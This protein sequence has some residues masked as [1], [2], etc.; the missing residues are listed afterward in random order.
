MLQNDIFYHS[1]IRKHII[2]MGTLINDLKI[3]R[4]DSQGNLKAVI[5]VPLSYAPKE[6]HL[7]RTLNDPNIDRPTA[8]TTLP[9]I[10]F[11][12]VSMAY[13]AD[14][15]RNP[16]NQITQKKID[17]PNSNLFMYVPIP[18]NF[19][20]NVYIYVKNAEDGTKI[21]EQILP[22]FTPAFVPS[23]ELIPEPSAIMD[24]P[25][26]FENMECEDIYEGDFKKRRV[27]IWTIRFAMK[28]WLFGP[29]RDFPVIK[30]ANTSFYVPL[31]GESEDTTA[32]RIANG[33]IDPT[34]TFIIQPGLTANGEPTSN[35]ELSIPVGDIEEDDDFGFVTLRTDYPPHE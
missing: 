18:Y 35:S 33:T 5:R 12:L 17:A 16:L 19:F 9:T 1:L 25:I 23:V 28:G 20:F 7:A 2:T 29:I 11:E 13:D 4:R 31:K 22:F 34:V 8:T 3:D 14:R 6:K 21:M 30:F 26:I 24:I 27:L 15:M 32:G 10:S